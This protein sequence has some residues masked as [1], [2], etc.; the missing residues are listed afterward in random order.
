MTRCL[1]FASALSA[2]RIFFA[3]I[4]K[5]RKLHSLIDATLL[6]AGLTVSLRIVSR[7]RVTLRITRSPARGLLTRI[8]KS[9]AYRAKRWPR[10]S[11]SPSS[12]FSRMLASN[13]DFT[14]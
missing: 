8:T 14:P 9:S 2:Q 5:P 10:V 13:G 11:N 6:L 12:W 4:V 1:K 3:T 7:Y